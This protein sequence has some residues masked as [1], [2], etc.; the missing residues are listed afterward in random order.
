MK[1]RLIDIVLEGA[2][3]LEYKRTFEEHAELCA[4]EGIDTE[5]PDEISERLNINE[6]EMEVKITA[7]WAY[8]TENI[9]S[10]IMY[11]DKTIKHLQNRKKQREKEKQNLLNYVGF[12][13]RLYGDKNKS[14]NYFFKTPYFKVTASPKSSVNVYNEEVVPEE[15]KQDVVTVK[16]DKKEIRKRMLEGEIIDGCGLNSDETNVNFR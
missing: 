9:D 13:L 1:K 12:C 15:F 14:G 6:D 2:E 16:I 3:L 8:I 11:L 5:M 4:M 10:D 7:T